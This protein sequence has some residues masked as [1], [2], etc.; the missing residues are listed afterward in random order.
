MIK[1]SI[2]NN[3][4]AVARRLEKLPEEIANK[5]MARALNKTVEQGRTQ[6]ARTIAEEFR[7]TVGDA[8]RRLIIE[9][10]SFRG[11]L[12]LRAALQAQ[13]PGGL[14]GNGERGM[15]L[16]NFAEKS[17]TLAAARKRIK[18]GEGGSYSLRNGATVHKALQVQFQIK[19]SGGKKVI[20]GAFIATNKRTGGTAVFIREGKSRYPIK[21]LTTI[22]IPQMFNTRRINQVVRQVMLEKLSSNFDRELRAILKGF[23]K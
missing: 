14:H 15:N 12:R 11:A 16:I 6:M 17:I 2:R 1:L 3:F 10:A 21:T 4:P 9:R 20:P 7:V 23:V 18:A 13:R 19:R 22:D 5:A 8:K